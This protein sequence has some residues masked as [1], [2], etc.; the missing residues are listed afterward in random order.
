MFLDTDQLRLFKL[1]YENQ[2]LSEAAGRYPMSV[3]KA[4]RLLTK[5]RDT[6][7][8]E[9]F[10]RSNQGLFPTQLANELYPKVLTIIKDIESLQENAA[11]SPGTLERTFVIGC[12]D[13]DI[14]AVFAPLLP[15]LKEVAPGVKIHFKNYSYD[16]YT[17]LRQGSLDFVFYPLSD[18]FAGFKKQAL[19]R[20]SFV[21]V[22]R[23]DSLLATRARRGERLKEKELQ[24]NLV[25]Q[26]TVPVRN[27]ENTYLGIFSED[28][29]S[30]P[31]DTKFFSPFFTS[32]PYFLNGEETTVIPLQTA[33]RMSEIM[34]IEILGRPKELPTY[35]YTM[36][37]YEPR[38]KD[39]AHQWF[40]SWL[41]AET[42]KTLVD[43]EKV[44]RLL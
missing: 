10:F 39:P 19:T 25:V 23:V 31:F 18:V 3:S 4:S 44:P 29:S 11:F 37:W 22:A 38:G 17:H 30:C 9:L 20:G 16:F 28:V 27:E 42:E 2:S 1:I 36:V 7:G 32:V 34:P 26:P 12:L 43:V 35:P 41:L 24:T 13:I 21:Y 33:V 15:K 5:M 8:G 40:R 14:I 6:F